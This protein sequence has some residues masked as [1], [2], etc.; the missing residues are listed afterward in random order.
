MSRILVLCEG[1]TEELALRYFIVKQWQSDGLGSVGLGAVNLRGKSPN[2]GRFATR[3]LD[4]R[5]VLAVFTLVDLQG[6]TQVVHQPQD[7]LE[8]KVQRVQGWLHAQLN[9]PRASD[10]FPHVCVHQTEAWILA[11]GGALA[12]RLNDPG[13]EPDPDAELKDFQ[14]PPSER[15]NKLF[16]RIKSR[17]YNKVRDGTPLF[18]EMEFTPVYNS[19]RYF[20]GFYDDLTAVGRR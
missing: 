19:C 10:F 7:D 14:N 20:R 15:L 6:L 4:D 13:I 17:R 11:E 1:K 16:L 3:Y 18:S 12:T 8:L 2:S 5:E 9:H